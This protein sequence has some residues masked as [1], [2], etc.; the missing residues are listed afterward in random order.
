VNN[1]STQP[2]I[3]GI[4]VAGACARAFKTAL[5]L[6]A[7]AAPA[8]SQT[9]TPPSSSLAAPSVEAL[10]Q[11]VST[12]E[13]EVE[14]LKSAVHQLQASAP[15]PP[16]QPRVI[17]AS[18]PVMSPALPEAPAPSPASTTT[19]T[20]IAATPVTPVT[21]VTPQTPSALPAQ[22]ATPSASALQPDDS[23]L[24]GFFHDTT[25]NVALDGYYD[26]N[27]N[28]PVGRVNLLRA[29]DVLSNEFSLNQA[30]VI[31]D[32]PADPTDG[33]RW[34]GRLDLQ[35]GQATDTLQGNPNNEPRPDIYR[36]IYQAYGTYIAPIGK[37]LEIDFGKWGSSLGIEGNYTKDQMNY[38]RSYFFDFLPFYH[39]GVRVSLPVSDKFTV[40]YWVVNGTNQ[41]EATNGFKDELFGFV[42][43]PTKTITWTSN[44]Y[45]GQEHPDREVSATPTNPIPVQPDLNF[46]AIRPA[47][48]GRTHIFDNYVTWQPTPKLTVALE[49]DYFIERLWRDQAPGES[50]APSHV[51]GGAA[52]LQYQFTPRMTFA[53][54]AEYL[55][56]RGGLFS[57]I[58]QALKENTVT[59]DYKLADGFLMRYEWRRDYSNQP[60]FLSDTQ[61][62]LLKQQTTAT[63][64]LLW[65]WGRKEGAW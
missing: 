44:Y 24:L 37:G 61:G 30:D 52:Y 17:L 46:V 4:H 57:G 20:A 13:S 26:Y 49:G 39:M 10:Q 8:R 38:S 25:I 34:G 19:I 21:P 16:S 40:N 36:N 3:G 45:L 42:Y 5:L 35:F 11:R 41:V 31:F 12:L 55:S 9:A 54:R 6:L 60:S 2:L 59:F 48:N 28:A 64:G 56:D 22:A 23:K 15:V 29:Y 63:V 62:L 27:F 32:H 43:K 65:W 58:T 18:A 51:V 47:P 50:A 7:L 53:T 33:R 14:A 1:Q